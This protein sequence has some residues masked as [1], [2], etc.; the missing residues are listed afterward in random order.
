MQSNADRLHADTA[1]LKK[2]VNDA[3][4]NCPDSELKKKAMK[5]MRNLDHITA[6]IIEKSRELAT[7]TGLVIFR[8]EMTSFEIRENSFFFF[9]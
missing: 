1:Q 9:F 3:F 7:G 6:V 2:L 8:G 4:K 5:A